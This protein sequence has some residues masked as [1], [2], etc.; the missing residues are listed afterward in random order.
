MAAAW[1]YG[2]CAADLTRCSCDKSTVSLSMPGATPRSVNMRGEGEPHASSQERRKCEPLP[3][4][5]AASAA[6][7][8]LVQVPCS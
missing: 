5:F 7:A 1:I 8:R 6:E 2:I 3:L 4:K